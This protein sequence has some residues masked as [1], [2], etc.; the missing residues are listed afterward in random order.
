MPQRKPKPARPTPARKQ[1]SAEPNPE[2]IYSPD[3]EMAQILYE[4]A[5]Q[6][7]PPHIDDILRL[8]RAEVAQAFAAEV[9]VVPGNPA[10]PPETQLPDKPTPP[11]HKPEPTSVRESKPLPRR[12]PGPRPK[13][14]WPTHVKNKVRSLK[15]SGKPIPT[16]VAFCQLCEDERGYQPDIRQ[17]QRLLKGLRA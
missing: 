5:Q 12:K 11:P 9:R 15:Q 7:Q 4:A 14:D 1:K 16:A 2:R 17:M 8:R 3:A 10:P 6:P 13:K